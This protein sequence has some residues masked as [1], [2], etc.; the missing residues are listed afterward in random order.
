VGQHITSVS[1]LP[2]GHPVRKILASAAVEGY[3]RLNQ[4]K[5]LKEIRASPNF[6]VD[7]LLEVKETLK[8]VH[9]GEPNLTFKEPFSGKTLP[10]V[11]K[12]A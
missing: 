12:S 6:A 5:F 3:I 2:D 7:L 11:T 10:F 8:T 1:L 9:S 4:H